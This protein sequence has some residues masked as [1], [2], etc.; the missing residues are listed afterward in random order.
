MDDGRRAMDDAAQGADDGGSTESAGGIPRRA[1]I[2]R[3]AIAGGALVW[4]T[5]VVQSMGQGKAYAWFRGS[6]E[7]GGCRCTQSVLAIAPIE[8]HAEP[9]TKRRIA[10]SGKYVTL[11]ASTGAD[12]GD[13]LGCN[14]Q[15]ETF[16]W[17]EVSA[18]GCS[19]YQQAGDTCT[20]RVTA[21]PASIV[22]HV[23]ATLVC[24]G[25]RG[26]TTSCTDTKVGKICFTQ[27]TGSES[28][29]CGRFEPHRNTRHGTVRCH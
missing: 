2:R 4:A 18:E 6:D 24:Q 29:R 13:R 10:L 26:H 22:L 14:P 20:V 8:C 21:Y 5:P 16:V 9:G 19:L 27:V 23:V 7:P 17:S 25:G 3:A 1:M 15:S 11:Q 28:Q 12:C